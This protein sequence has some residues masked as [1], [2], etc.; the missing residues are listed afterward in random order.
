ME[1]VRRVVGRALPLDRENVDTDQIIPA[2]WLK[3]IERTGYGAGLFE[4]WRHDPGFALND[5]R[6]A[7]AAILVAGANF[8][9]GSSRE[10]AAWALLEGGFHAVIAPRLADI[11]KQNAVKNG[12]VPVELPASA[13]AALMRAV[14]KDPALE[15]VVDVDTRSVAAP[16][17]GLYVLFPLDERSRASLLEGRDEIAQTEQHDDEITA[18]ETARPAWMPATLRRATT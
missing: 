10:H 18:Y 14:E 11:F 13:V 8:G 16:A 3:R 17:I 1:P 2:H 6:Y 7:G 4:A 15:I 5:A 12:L 9:S